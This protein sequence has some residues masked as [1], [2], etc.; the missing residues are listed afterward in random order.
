MGP[1]SPSR[2]VGRRDG[3]SGGTHPNE[4]ALAKGEPVERSIDGFRI[5]N[6]PSRLALQHSGSRRSDEKENESKGKRFHGGGGVR[7]QEQRGFVSTMLC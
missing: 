1:F 5:A 4:L 2:A 7:P 3:S 6:D